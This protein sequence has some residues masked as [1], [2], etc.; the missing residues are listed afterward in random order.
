MVFL[1]MASCATGPAKQGSLREEVI[2]VLQKTE[3]MLKE[4]KLDNVRDYFSS[5]Y[6]GGF[7]ELERQIE[8]R[9]REEQL[10]SLEFI[11]NR[12][13]ENDGI[14][15]VQVRWHKSFLDARG[16]PQRKSGTSE[17]LLQPEGD[18]FRFLHISGDLFF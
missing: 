16:N 8:D 17:I 10:I 3:K 2:G 13:L 7:D 15:N 4:E 5:V 14:L 6:F 9:W 12:I 18:S 1:I 11:V